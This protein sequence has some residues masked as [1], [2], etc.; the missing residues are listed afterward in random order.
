[1]RVEALIFGEERWINVEHPALPF[2]YEFRG[3]QAHVTGEGE[4]IGSC[5]AKL[6]IDNRVEFGTLQATVGEGEGSNALRLRELQD[7]S[8]RVV[9]CDQHDLKRA[10]GA[11]GR[12][13]QRGTV[14]T[15]AGNEHGK[16]G[17]ISKPSSQP[18]T[19]H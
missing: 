10:I 9:R 15:A 8:F 11:L 19:S 12:T 13:D 4:I 6:G 18:E 14:R 16:F 17:F 7:L 5:L 3:E 1:M 2:A